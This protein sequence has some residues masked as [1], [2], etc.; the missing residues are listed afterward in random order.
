MESLTHARSRESSAHPAVGDL[1][2]CTISA[3]ARDRSGHRGCCAASP[4]LALHEEGW[5]VAREWRSRRAGVA[6]CPVPHGAFAL[7]R[8]H[9]P[10]LLPAH[11]RR[12]RI[13]GTAQAATGGGSGQKSA[14]G[15]AP[16][17]ITMN[18]KARAR[19]CFACSSAASKC[20]THRR[21]AGYRRLHLSSRVRG[22]TKAAPFSRSSVTCRAVRAASIVRMSCSG[23]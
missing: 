23:R 5:G 19:N 1:D 22:S 21:Y 17:G 4:S 13:S 11:A 15:H 6:R 18:H 20:L 3:V 10:K 16:P 7:K 14:R 2:S 12:P 8:P 9:G